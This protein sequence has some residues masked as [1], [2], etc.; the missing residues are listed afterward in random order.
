MDNLVTLSEAEVGRARE[1]VEQI[2]RASGTTF[3]WAMR[4]LPGEKRRAMFA[5]YAFCRIVDDIA[6]DPNPLDVKKRE[7]APWREEIRSL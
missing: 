4:L 7:L 5:V 2:V 3:Y 1:Q 6:D